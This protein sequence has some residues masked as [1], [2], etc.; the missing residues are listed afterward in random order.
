M[1][2]QKKKRR[3]RETL[4]FCHH[5]FVFL[6]EST[7]AS[8]RVSREQHALEETCVMLSVRGVFADSRA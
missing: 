8:S 5:R 4:S 3:T 2:M 1:M 6:L 7:M